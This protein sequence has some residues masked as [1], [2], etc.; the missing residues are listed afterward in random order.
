M[1]MNRPKTFGELTDDD[2]V[3]I[4][5]TTYIAGNSIYSFERLTDDKLRRLTGSPNLCVQIYT[6]EIPS[7]KF[8][9]IAGKVDISVSEFKSQIYPYLKHKELWCYTENKN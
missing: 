9:E 3:Y 7:K 4:K 5:S 6:V 1:E 8:R 2:Y